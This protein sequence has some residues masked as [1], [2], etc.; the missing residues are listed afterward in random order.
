MNKSLLLVAALPLLL[1]ACETPAD[2]QLESFGLQI[3]S[4]DPEVN[5]FWYEGSVAGQAT[6]TGA[7]RDLTVTIDGADD[8]VRLDVHSPAL[9]DLTV[10]DGTDVTVDLS[11]GSVVIRDDE[12]IAYAADAGGHRWQLEEE[13]GQGFVDWGSA[14]RTELD[15]SEMYTYTTAVFQ[16]DDGPVVVHPGDSD[17]VRIDGIDWDVTV[18]AAYKVEETVP[19]MALCGGTPD[20]LSYEMLRVE[21]VR[22]PRTIA[23]PE[24]LPM[25]TGVGGCG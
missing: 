10:F 21:Q 24:G 9:T 6:V 12:G 3:T 4:D 18:I 7:E 2:Q 14:I 20:V 13:L 8:E 16:G 22:E 11:M 15:G 19:F 5:E 1:A 17:T 23:R 25:A